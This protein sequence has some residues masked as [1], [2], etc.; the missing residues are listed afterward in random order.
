MTHRTRWL[1]TV[2][3]IAAAAVVLGAAIAQAVRQG[4]PYPYLAGRLDSRSGGRRPVPAGFATSP[5]ATQAAAGRVGGGAAQERRNGY[6]PVQAA[7][8]LTMPS[9][10]RLIRLPSGSWVGFT[11]VRTSPAN[12][13][14]ARS[15][16]RHA[17]ACSSRTPEP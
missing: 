12:D 5:Q 4:A 14:C 1:V 17:T 2:G 3:S 10:Y 8:A 9:T 11:S 15:T 16:R 7:S 6:A 13:G